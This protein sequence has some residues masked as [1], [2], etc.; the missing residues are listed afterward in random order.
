MAQP[1]PTTSLSSAPTLPSL[2]LG[3]SIPTSVVH[4]PPHPESAVSWRSNPSD[5]PDPSE[6]LVSMWSCHGDGPSP[7]SVSVYQTPLADG[8]DSPLTALP[9]SE[10]SIKG[11]H[12]PRPMNSWMLFRA[13]WTRKHKNE[14]KGNLSAR[15]AVEWRVLSHAERAV[16]IQK[17]ELIKKEHARM[18]PDYKYRPGRSKGQL[19]NSSAAIAGESSRF[20]SQQTTASATVPVSPAK[21]ESPSQ[22][23]RVKAKVNYS[24]HSGADSSRS[25]SSHSRHTS[26]PADLDAFNV[27]MSIPPPPD[28]HLFYEPS[29]ITLP[30]VVATP[31]RF[32]APT[33]TY[34]MVIPEVPTSFITTSHYG[35]DESASYESLPLP[36][37]LYQTGEPEPS[38]TY[39]LP[40][41]PLSQGN[42]PHYSSEYLAFVPRTYEEATAHSEPYSAPLLMPTPKAERATPC[43]RYITKKRSFPAPYQPLMYNGGSRSAAAGREPPRERLKHPWENA[44]GAPELQPQYGVSGQMGPPEPTSIVPPLPGTLDGYVYAPTLS[45]YERAQQPSTHSHM[46][47]IPEQQSTPFPQ[48]PCYNHDAGRLLKPIAPYPV[49]VS[50]SPSSSSSASFGTGS[51][52]TTSSFE[53]SSPFRPPLPPTQLGADAFLE[54]A[55]I[56]LQVQ[57]GYAILTNPTY[58]APES[59]ES[60]I[61]FSVDTTTQPMD[62]VF[63]DNG[64]EEANRYATWAYLHAPQ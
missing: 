58:S 43:R 49:D 48:H 52:P 44:S 36:P 26:Q 54:N 23:C 63:M 6:F 24:M 27:P 15:A 56:D 25:A 61:L 11:E 53:S 41:Q 4:P 9:N 62:V 30:T 7:T 19:G 31:M 35:S 32:A 50:S 33:P 2:F 22:A 18:Y 10:E 55:G 39:T 45:V 17:A 13:D 57:S 21:L 40:P 42:P 8:G 46:P 3:S 60:E 5:Q 16:W 14:Q 34:S 51:L 64:L 38:A 1:I 59:H 29:P 37:D 20:Q 12:I 47:L 28:H